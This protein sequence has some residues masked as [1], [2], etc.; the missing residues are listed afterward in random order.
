MVETAPPIPPDVLNGMC[1]SQRVLELVTS[2]WSVLVLYALRL[3][4]LGYAQLERKVGGISQ[5]MLT[6]TLRDL[7][8]HGLISRTLYPVVPPRT[9]Y[10]LTELGHSLEDVVYQIGHWAETHM[11]EVLAAKEQYDARG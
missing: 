5:K 2:K 8:R 4:T 10:Q 7:E 11:L 3:H 9:E 1:P 6:Q